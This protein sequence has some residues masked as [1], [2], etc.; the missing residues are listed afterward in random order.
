MVTASY[1]SPEMLS[2]HNACV[3]VYNFCFLLLKKAYCS[4]KQAGVTIVNE[5]GMDPGIDHMLTMEVAD[6]AHEQ[7]GKVG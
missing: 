2:L 4:A 1:Q 3:T 5:V 7:G 6:N